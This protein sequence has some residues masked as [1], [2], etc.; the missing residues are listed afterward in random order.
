MLISND[1]NQQFSTDICTQLAG[2]I[3]LQ[4]AQTLAMSCEK[5]SPLRRFASSLVV[6]L[7]NQ[8]FSPRRMQPARNKEK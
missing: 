6:L 5:Q 7:F 2:G 8:T 4:A 1:L 3:V